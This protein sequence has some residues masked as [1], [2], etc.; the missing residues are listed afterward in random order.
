M[1]MK[2][3]KYR[4]QV[5][6][7]VSPQRAIYMCSTTTVSNK[8]PVSSS[9]NRFLGSCCLVL[10]GSIMV[11]A[12]PAMRAIQTFTG[13]EVVLSQSWIQQRALLNNQYLHQLNAD[14]LLHNF[15]V[16][17]GI[18]STAQPLEGWEHPKV[19][20]RG[21]FTGHYLSACSY[22][23]Y[24]TGD[25]GLQ[26]RLQYMV[27]ALA[28][29]Q[30]KAGGYYLSAFSEK[31]FDILE[32]QFGGVWAPY[33]TYHKIMQG[34][35][36]AY[37]YGGNQQALAVVKNMATYVQ[38]RMAKLSPETIEKVLYTPQA[39]PGNEVGGMNDVLH[40]LY[41]VTKDTLHLQLAKLFDRDWFSKPLMQ[42]KDILSG[43][44]ANTHLVLVNG[45]VQRYKNTRENDYGKAAF[46]FWDMLMYHH[47]FVNGSS[48]GPRPIATTST[49]KTA[50][51]W[52][53]A[54][55]LS[56]TLTDEIAE[57]CVSHNTQKLT[58]ALFQLSGQVQYAQSYMNTF[59]NAVMALQNAENGQ[60][61]YH[62]PLASP[63]KK[64]F[65]KEN[66]FKCC[67]GTGIEAF[68]N[69]NSNVY[70]HEK[71]T[72]WINLYV[73]SQLN[74]ASKGMTLQQ[75]GNFTELGKVRIQLQE[76]QPKQTTIK[77]LV[78]D[79]ADPKDVHITI[80]GI[81]VP[82][83]VIHRGYATLQRVWKAG[84][85]VEMTFKLKIRCVSMKDDAN[86]VAFYYGPTL[87]AFET[88]KELI[89]KGTSKDIVTSIKQ[90][91]SNLR[92]QM[93][94]NQQTYRLVPFYQITKAS[95]GVYATIRNDY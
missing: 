11:A 20:L 12:Q 51:H 36:D 34:M 71:D 70:F 24:N 84:D 48:S 85:V 41:A 44:H 80:N 28:E 82:S 10:F 43:L 77:C 69:L 21:H 35:L 13:K 53:K 38:R 89:L 66:D 95:Y 6:N 26:N 55:V 16:N 86:I 57:S 59:Y 32:K 14:R 83:K 37:T 1:I 25:T 94:N 73:P 22:A 47:A 68:A 91:A 81:P 58:S 64:V 78:P 92:F 60:V 29:C 46:H 8:K 79:W 27:K 67:N 42:N 76:A 3:S 88:D 90:D 72:L 33:Y 49:A 40:Q 9:I 17:V 63:R 61:V 74:W 15:R 87:L 50:E 4:L 56:T 54:D 30:Q 52:G 93:T 7:I 23:I 75:S 62:L 18:A 5:V 45:F 2:P 31:D 39:N 19:G 65:L